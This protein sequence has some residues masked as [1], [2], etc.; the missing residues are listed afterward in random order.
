MGLGGG[1]MVGWHPATHQ[2]HP[3]TPR[4]PHSHPVT[5]ENLWVCVCTRVLVHVCVCVSEITY[6]VPSHLPTP[7]HAHRNTHSPIHWPIHPASPAHWPIHLGRGGHF[8][9]SN[10]NKCRIQ[11]KSLSEKFQLFT[12]RWT[13]ELSFGVFQMLLLLFLRKL[14]AA[15]TN[16]T[17]LMAPTVVFQI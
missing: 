2:T 9:E 12:E 3:A 5:P 1:W 6:Q 11:T 8:D 7:T 16:T 10:W 14:W 4:H 15:P 17:Y 13:T